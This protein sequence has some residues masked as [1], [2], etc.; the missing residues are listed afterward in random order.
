MRAGNFWSV[1]SMPFFPFSWGQKLDKENAPKLIVRNFDC[2]DIISSSPIE[3]IVSVASANLMVVV[4]TLR[5]FSAR[6]AIPVLGLQMFVTWPD[7][8]KSCVRYHDQL[9][10]VD[11]GPQ[12]RW[13]NSARGFDA[14]HR[15]RKDDAHAIGRDKRSMHGSPPERVVGEVMRPNLNR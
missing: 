10:L 2:A 14:C 13:F 1:R 5:P 11:T 7:C 9:W 8:G 12:R 3:T 6:S 4:R 15:C